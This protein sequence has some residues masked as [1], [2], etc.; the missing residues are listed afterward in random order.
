MLVAQ[1]LLLKDQG[2]HVGLASSFSLIQMVILHLLQS[3]HGFFLCHQWGLGRTECLQLMSRE[4]LWIG[5]DQWAFQLAEDE[6]VSVRCVGHL[7]RQ[8]REDRLAF[9]SAEHRLVDMLL[10]VISSRIFLVEVVGP[11]CH[12]ALTLLRGLIQRFLVRLILNILSIMLLPQVL[13]SAVVRFFCLVCC[14]SL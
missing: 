10:V 1:F 6:L 5:S 3:L 11:H 13:L 8:L 4:L 9:V 7:L 14:N 2:G 12:Y